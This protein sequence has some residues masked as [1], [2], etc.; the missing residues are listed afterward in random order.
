MTFRETES[1]C[2]FA[3]SAGS[4]QAESRAARIHKRKNN[5]GF[6]IVCI[7]GFRTESVGRIARNAGT[8]KGNSATVGARIASDR[9]ITVE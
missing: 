5:N 1:D 7:A 8:Y 2:G 6:W 3:F 9:K 4:A